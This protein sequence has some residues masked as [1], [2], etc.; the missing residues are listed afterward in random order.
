MYLRFG[1]T[2]TSEGPSITFGWWC[3]WWQWWWWWWRYW[4]LH[5]KKVALSVISPRTP[6]DCCWEE[7][8]SRTTARD[9][10]D[11]NNNN[12]S[13]NITS[14][15]IT[16]KS[17][18]YWPWLDYSYQINTVICIILNIRKAF[19]TQSICET[20]RG[21]VFSFV[22]TFMNKNCLVTLWG[23]MPEVEFKGVAI[24]FFWYEL[25]QALYFLRYCV[26]ICWDCCLRMEGNSMRR[27]TYC[28]VVEKYFTKSL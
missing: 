22:M 20:N 3:R 1:L 19:W 8:L 7:R 13:H 14:N 16:R 23:R 2:I 18:T 17:A 10:K 5:L 26:C 15:N 11:N 9:Q 25:V 21:E 6:P 24:I 28:S 12:C 4:W 27:F